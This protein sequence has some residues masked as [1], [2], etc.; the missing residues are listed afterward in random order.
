MAC[1][2]VGALPV[3]VQNLASSVYDFDSR[4]IALEDTSFLDVGG[5]GG[6]LC[7]EL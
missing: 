6:R 7:Q 5:W 2:N 4:L 3:I 1:S